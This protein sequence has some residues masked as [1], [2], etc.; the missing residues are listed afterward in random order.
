M[1]FPWFSH[2]FPM[3]FPWFSHGFP[4]KIVIFTG[5]LFVY[6]MVEHVQSTFVTIYFTIK[7]HH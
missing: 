5:K 4:I 2:G 1:V 7:P 3:V 6:Q